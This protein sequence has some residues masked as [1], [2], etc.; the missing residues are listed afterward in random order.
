MSQGIEQ[1][2]DILEQLKPVVNEPTFN[3][4]LSQVAATVPKTKRFLLKMELKRQAKPTN[5]M[6]D[7]RGRVDGKCQ[8]YEHDG[9]THFL[10]DVAT[11]VFER[12]VRSFG[13]YTIGVYESVTNT[14]NNFR[15]KH[16]AKR[17][18]LAQE[19]DTL[20]SAEQQYQT[21]IISFTGV[22]QRREER[23][24]F[25]VEVE[26]FTELDESVHA[27]SIDISVSGLKL[28]ISKRHLLKPGEKLRVHFRGLSAE[29]G[30]SHRDSVSYLITDVDRSREEQRVSLKRLY[31]KDQDAFDELLQ[32]L[33]QSNKRRYKINLENT[34]DAIMVKGY[35][36][37]YIPHITSVPVFIEYNE[38]DSLTPKYL[39]SNDSNRDSIQFWNDEGG[40]LRL[41]YLFTRKR[42][43]YLLQKS[44][45]E[46]HTYLFVF[47]HTAQGRV[48]FY[49]ATLEELEA[50][51]KLRECYLAYGSRKAS[52]RVYKLQLTDM[53]PEQCHT[54][55]SLPDSVNDRIRR[56]NMPPSARLMAKLKNLRHIALITD[57]SN[58]WN[59]RTYQRR[60]LKRELLSELQIFCHPRNRHPAEITPYRFQY[61]E[62][63]RENRFMLRTTVTLHIGNDKVDGASED[64]SPSGL[65][66]ELEEP[67]NLKI[68]DDV[69][70]FFPKLAKQMSRYELSKVY[71]Q[72][73]R[74]SEDGM[75]LHFRLDEQEKNAK[76]FFDDL[77]RSNKRKLRNKGEPR[78]MAGVGEALRNIY[79]ANVVN[80]AMFISK[81]G[82]ALKPQS[83][84]CPPPSHRLYSLFSHRAEQDMLNL[85][86][87][88]CVFVEGKS[89][90]EQAIRHLRTHHKPASYELLIAFNPAAEEIAEAIQVRVSQQF[91]DDK[92]RRQFIQEA[93][94]SG[95][96][97]ALRLFLTRTG[98][99]DITLLNTELSY[100]SSYAVHR[101]KLLEEQL[102]SIAAVGDVLDVTTEVVYRYGLFA[103]IRQQTKR[104]G[105]ASAKTKQPATTD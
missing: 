84:T 17:T 97:F 34:I 26:A 14:E 66:V 40:V 2:Q 10:D 42:L 69:R 65:K 98:R 76:Q 53:H 18:Q 58:E 62:L 22:H 3:Q 104:L 83:V 59:M 75:V 82:I 32:R 45:A 13:G 28:K 51:P 35:E 80:L 24:N 30:L 89:F 93:L 99:P 79:A 61:Q 23:M 11:E 102:W 57:I 16:Q 100:V 19:G 38:D 50:H 9:I 92:Q 49:S 29:Y 7:L 81:E 1:Y 8:P 95:Q 67:T 52:W 55:L 31:D 103:K 74:I 39:I 63:R 43:Q 101:A 48:Y 73:V 37:Y 96:F 78:D 27:R 60:N 71:Y 68:G 20:L 77:I 54:P 86:P 94:D 33:I 44:E 41:G 91:K 36:Q 47:T 88:F 72:V 15:V 85:F 4:I 87:L 6:I 21:P 25:V 12:Q 46:R 105:N 64:L 90:V 56:M 5:R 70:L